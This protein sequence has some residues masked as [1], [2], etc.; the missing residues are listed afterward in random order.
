MMDD[1]RY[2][3]TAINKIETYAKNG[4]FMGDTLLATFESRNKPLN[5]KSVEAIIKKFLQNNSICV[6]LT[7]QIINLS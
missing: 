4:M 1:P 5:Q 7:T 6:I 2:A 3:E